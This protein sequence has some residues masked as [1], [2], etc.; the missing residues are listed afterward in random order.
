MSAST[1]EPRGSSSG[2]R[3]ASASSSFIGFSRWRGAK[4][5]GPGFAVAR[6][7]RGMATGDLDGDGRPEI[8]IVNLNE[9]PTLLKNVGPRQNAIAI[10]L[11]GTRSN[12]SA[13]GARCTIET[14]SRKQM[15]DVVS[16]GSYYSQSD[17]TLYFGIGKADKIDRLEVRWPNGE[18]QS[19]TAISPNRTLRIREGRNDFDEQPFRRAPSPR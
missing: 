6:P 14:G 3:W 9:R 10:R 5:T 2:R 19:W 18:K 11:T 4:R 13:I 7:S 16:G 12:R 15:A 1:R 8:V 17:F